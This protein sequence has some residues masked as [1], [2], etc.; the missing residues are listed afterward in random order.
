MCQVHKL[1]PL[2]Q[3]LALLT[4][5][6]EYKNEN[7]SWT[8]MGNFLIYRQEFS[9]GNLNLT[10]PHCRTGSELSK[11]KRNLQKPKSSQIFPL[12]K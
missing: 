11:Y 5:P 7:N 1:S 9:E 8:E 12:A 2:H 6:L 3:H 10:T 4:E